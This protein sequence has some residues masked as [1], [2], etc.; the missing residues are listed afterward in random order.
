M[1]EKLLEVLATF[2][3]NPDMD[4]AEMIVNIDG[5]EGRLQEIYDAIK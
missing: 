1:D 2:W 3:W 4:I 5:A